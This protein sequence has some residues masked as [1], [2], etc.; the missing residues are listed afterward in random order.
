MAQHHDLEHGAVSRAPPGA[1][2]V[3]HLNE[4]LPELATSAVTAVA[5]RR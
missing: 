4:L 3:G 2:P 5:P 1:A